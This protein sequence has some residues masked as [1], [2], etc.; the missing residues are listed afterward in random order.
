MR[1]FL[2][3][4]VLVSVIV[5]LTLIYVIPSQTPFSAF[6][7]SPLGLSLAER[8][9]STSDKVV[10]IVQPHHEVTQLVNMYLHENYTIVLVG[11]NNVINETLK[12]FGAYLGPYSVKD[13]VF[14]AG[15]SSEVEVFYDGQVGIL[16]D[17]YPIYNVSPMVETSGFSYAGHQRGPF[18]VVGE[19]RLKGG[20]T[21][22]VISSP[23]V[24]TN[25]FIR[26][27]LNFL[28]A[29]VGKSAYI[30]PNPES[31]LDYVKLA[32]DSLPNY[33]LLALVLSLL[34][35]PIKVKDEN[36]RKNKDEII[37]RVLSLHPDWDETV[38]RRIYDDRN[39]E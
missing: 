12:E 9:F 38:L 37:K 30:Y 36:I 26:D 27:N 31:P 3:I 35:L 14:N 34:I 18:T 23:Y 8:F 20:A 25:Y 24:M 1:G 5:V 29:V 11:N 32:L 2:L 4:S 22:I 39:K 17:S 33:S 6:S 28:Y 7:G 13:P 15:N 21:V 10:V 19:I 16:Y